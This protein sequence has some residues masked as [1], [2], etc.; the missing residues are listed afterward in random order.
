MAAPVA[1]ADQE[2]LQRFE[3]FGRCSKIALRQALALLPEIVRRKLY[4]KAGFSSPYEFASKKTG[5]TRAVVDKVLRLHS[6]IGHLPA[7][8]GLLERGEE[9]WSKL[10]VIQSIATQESEAKL[11]RLVTRASKAELEDYAR[12]VKQ[13]RGKPREVARPSSLQSTGGRQD[14]LDP[15]L[16]LHTSGSRAVTLFLTP[17]DD[18]LLRALQEQH[19]R[20]HGEAIALG[21]VVGLLLR[22]EWPRQAPDRHDELD[23]S[24]LPGNREVPG[25]QGARALAK[26]LACARTVQVTVR[27][28][29]LQA[30][31]ACK[32]VSVLPAGIAEAFRIQETIALDELHALAIETASRSTGRE[33]PEAV[34]K[35]VALRAAMR[36][37]VPGCDRPIE[38][39]HHLTARCEGGDHHPDNIQALCA[40]H[41]GAIHSGAADDPAVPTLEAVSRLS[42][43]NR[44]F[45]AIRARISARARRRGA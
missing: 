24:G 45:Q 9:G 19:R 43:A 25:S 1:T 11:V 31:F 5:A 28:A 26:N 13:E 32:L 33:I 37:E 41:H 16:P 30:D 14:S 12:R 22:D 40:S 39:L 29:D 35:F 8:W 7:L 17:E 34:R 27:V 21:E 10:A 42:K 3:T 38:D 4:R 18:A 36:C 23:S 2:L 44:A 20:Q 6:A 15:P